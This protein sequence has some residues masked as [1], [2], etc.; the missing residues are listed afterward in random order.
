MTTPP[1]GR[2]GYQRPSN[3][4]PVS[5]P[6]ALSKRT[7]GGPGQP[8]RTPTGGAYG[9][10]A[11]LTGLQQAAPLAEAQGGGA[12]PPGLLAGLSLPEGVDLDA[13]TTEPGSPVTSGAELGAGP[14][15]EALGL[16]APKDADMRALL[17]FLPVFESMANVPGASKSS[18]NI[19]RQL[20]ALL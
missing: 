18:R 5:G 19:V 2:G 6:G 1:S 11:E 8:V 20:K 17:K 12:T 14:G 3:P 7:D 10:G 4:A 13:P 16:Q 15:L 9:E